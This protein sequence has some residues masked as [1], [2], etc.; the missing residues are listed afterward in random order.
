MDT[1]GTFIILIIFLII[2][3]TPI[4]IVI[5]IVNS[6][7]KAKKLKAKGIS[8]IAQLTHLEGLPLSSGIACQVISYA[9]RIEINGSGNQFNLSKDKITDICLKSKTETQ[10]Y[11]VYRNNIKAIKTTKFFLTIT[12]RNEDEIKY[13]IFYNSNKLLKF[14]KEFRKN[15]S[16]LTA[17]A[18]DL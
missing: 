13:V 7:S 1:Q 2:I 10:Q 15:K 3:A 16:T 9:D 5:A 12:Y 8:I 11:L 18:I 4:A 14:V 17:T 6:I